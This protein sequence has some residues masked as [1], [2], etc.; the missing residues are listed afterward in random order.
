MT[1]FFTFEQL[2]YIYIGASAVFIAGGVSIFLIRRFKKRR[3]LLSSLEFALYEITLPRE[4]DSKKEQASFKDLVSR[5]EQFYVGMSAV[6][7][8]RWFAPSSFA[9]ELA[10]PTVGEEAIFYVAVP[11]NRS[12]LFEKNLQSLYPSAK[13]EEKKEDYNIFNPLGASAAAF[14]TL[15]E[16]P[17]LPIRTYQRLDADPLEVIANAFSKLKKEGEGVAV[18]II[19]SHG[20]KN[21]KSLL[22]NSVKAVREGKKIKSSKSGFGESLMFLITGGSGEKSKKESITVDE[23]TL[24]LLEEKTSFPALNANIRIVA[25]A[26]TS[27]EAESIVHELGSAFRQFEEPGGNS[28][29]LKP[30]SRRNLDDF[31]YRFSFRIFDKKRA[32]T[33]NTREL[34][35]IYHF[36]TGTA[37]APSL[38]FLRAKDAP[39]PAGLPADGIILGENIYRG[40]SLTIKLSRDD[41]RRHLYIIGQTGT[42][43]TTLLQN[44]IKQDIESG[45]GLC[46]IDPHGDMIETVLGYIPKNRADDV[47]YFDPAE[48]SRPMGFNFLEYD[49]AYPEQKTFIVNE[50]LEIF[51]KLY[52]DVPEALGP[53]FETYFRNSTLLVM[54]DPLSGNTLLEISRVMSDAEFR[55]LKLSRS[56]NPVINSFWKD[57][58]EKAGGEAALANMVPYITSKFD[59][60]LTNEFM[61]PILLQEQSSLKFREI[62][63]GGK[64]LLVNLSKGRVGETNASLLGLIIVGKLM[65]AAFSRIN[66]LEEKRRDFY[67]YLD[68]FQN[69]TTPSIATI[70]SEARK[71]RLDLI[72]AHQFIGQLS[73]PIRLA[74]FGNVGSIASFRI[75]ADDAEFVQKQFEPVFGTQDLMNIENFNAYLKLLV[76][77]QTTKPF[78]IRVLAPQKSDTESAALIKNLSLQKYGRPRNEVEEEINR[79]YQKQQ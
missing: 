52:A 73:D 37:I 56:K 17:V 9:L 10:L 11:R 29:E 26:T 46:V 63:D 14:L 35:S 5:M 44:M 68:E 41:R 2:F 16:N 79:R 28:F 58:A 69:V 32:V 72:I 76:R 61:R 47:V 49:P 45:E 36:P 48:T 4:T 23:E 19:L 40:Q 25:S 77:G 74:V 60:F 38:K 78:N 42:G 24:K 30:V 64:I 57:V 39:A 15:A 27:E 54:E 7:E 8:K 33:L 66:I 70:L 51:R 59:T 53:I 50:L 55:K 71:Y 67:L 6:I 1:A 31:I 65:M 43:K 62:I 3:E 18:Q 12:R 21:F 34:T 22:K 13:A 75:G 20:P